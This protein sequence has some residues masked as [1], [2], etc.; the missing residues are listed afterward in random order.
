MMIRIVLARESSLRFRITRPSDVNARRLKMADGE[1]VSE[2]D[3][4]VV[5]GVS[6][7]P[8]VAAE[9]E[10]DFGGGGGG[11]LGDGIGGFS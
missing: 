7:A 11:R 10:E 9:L 3:L 5:D 1:T 6:P 2:Y 8:A 4:S